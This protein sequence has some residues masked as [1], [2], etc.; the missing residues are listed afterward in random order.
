L[1]HRWTI[2][3][4]GLCAVTALATMAACAPSPAAPTDPPALSFPA[5]VPPPVL[6][7]PTIKITNFMAF[8][9][10]L[11]EGEYWPGLGFQFFDPSKSYVAFFLQD[12][13]AR[14][15]TQSFVVANEGLGGETATE[16]DT[17]DRFVDALDAHHPQA[18]LLLEGINE[19]ADPS[20]RDSSTIPIIITA[21]RH[22]IQNARLRNAHVFLSTLTAERDPNPGGIDD[23]GYRD[24]HWLTDALLQEV[25]AAIRTLAA[26][27]SGVT[28]VDGYAVTAADPARLVGADGLHLSVEGYQ[29]LAAAFLDAVKA[30][31]E[32]P[33]PE[34]TW[35]GGPSIPAVG[36]HVE[37]RPEGAR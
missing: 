36:T 7:P 24:R 3:R 5:G 8:G 16:G 34:P 18:V 10:S 33:P 25:N 35:S 22:D 26:T 12:L 13:Q 1:T 20:D 19:F 29:A 30:R 21:L 27:E 28:L 37:V 23:P 4:R 17:S 31:Y 2:F 32:N 11:T 6:A 15:S 14:Y 9:D